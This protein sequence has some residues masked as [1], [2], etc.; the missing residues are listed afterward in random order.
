MKQQEFQSMVVG[1]S[2]SLGCVLS[3]V[4]LR[5]WRGC[6]VPFFSQP[7]GICGTILKMYLD[8]PKLYQG[9]GSS[10][11]WKTNLSLKVMTKTLPSQ[12]VWN[13]FHMLLECS[14]RKFWWGILGRWSVFLSEEARLSKWQWCAWL[15]ARTLWSFMCVLSVLCRVPR[16]QPDPYGLSNH[17]LEVQPLQLCLA[18]SIWVNY[19]GFRGLPV[20]WWSLSDELNH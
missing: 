2:G 19:L 13:R 20:K 1:N 3:H 7:W 4:Y 5:A 14:I 8:S 6:T 15:V 17:S 10:C 11:I 18:L 16:E 12:E 9:R